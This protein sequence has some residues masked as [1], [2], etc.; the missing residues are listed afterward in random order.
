MV[1]FR[2]DT[3]RFAYQFTDQKAENINEGQTHDRMV[4]ARKRYESVI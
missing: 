1:N 3:E 4:E 2:N